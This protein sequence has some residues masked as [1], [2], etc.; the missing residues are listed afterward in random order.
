MH[1]IDDMQFGQAGMHHLVFQQSARGDA[2]DM[3][4]A[5]IAVSATTPIKPTLR[6]KHDFHAA[7]VIARTMARVASL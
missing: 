2:D 4:P 7:A 3:G 6:R 1:G 5:A